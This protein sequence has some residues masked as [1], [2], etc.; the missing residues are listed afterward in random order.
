MRA[1]TLVVAALCMLSLTGC[2]GVDGSFKKLRDSVVHGSNADYQV[3]A[4]FGIGSLIMGMARKVVSWSGEPDAA[5]ALEMLQQVH[6]VQIGVYSLNPIDP[7]PL[8]HRDRIGMLLQ[9][10]QGQGYD[11]IVRNYAASTGSL[12]LIKSELEQRDRVREII[13]LSLDGTELSLIQLRGNVN[14]IVEI[15]A[16]EHELPGVEAAIDEAR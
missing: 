2:F 8:S 12:I 11:A 15:A 1:G 13:V 4:E 6:K 7:S 3:E 5:Q 16:R 9:H 14:E 10:L